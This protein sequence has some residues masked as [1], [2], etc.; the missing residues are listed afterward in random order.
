MI[1]MSWEPCILK[2]TPR[3]DDPYA[4]TGNVDKYIAEKKPSK[5]IM[6]Y[7]VKRSIVIEYPSMYVAVKSTK[8]VKQTIS[9][10]LTHSRVVKG[11]YIFAFSVKAL[12]DRMHEHGYQ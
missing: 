4:N 12:F 9:S 7:D 10:G 6:A 2:H 8:L 3:Y 5:P 11:V 1:D